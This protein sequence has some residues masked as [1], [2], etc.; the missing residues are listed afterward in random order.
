MRSTFL[1]CWA[2]LALITGCAVAP[3]AASPDLRTASDM[4]DADR[5]ARLHMELA[6][7]YFGRGQANTALDEVK[8]VIAVRPEMPEAY[9]LR[10]L[11]YASM[12]QPERAEE[13]F[14]QAL[15]LNPAD[16]DS[17]HNLG[18]FLCQEQRYAEAA[19]QFDR[20]MAQ[21][22][23]RDVPRTLLAKGLCQAR[24]GQLPEADRTLSRSFEMDPSNPATAFNLGEVLFR[25]GEFERA[26]FYLR[27]VNSQPA[28]A[29]AQSLWLAARVEHRLGNT[30]GLRLLGEQLQDRFP[31]SPEALRYERDQFDE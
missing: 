26:R 1:A 16:A 14:Q 30:P 5:R 20:A 3:P 7:G 29:N 23:Y 25:L 9:N 13:S 22:R 31:Q 10:G 6:S 24:A 21:P 18:W 8:K 15:K 2:V 12:G 19:A 11:I 27:R 17:M 4:T 28:T